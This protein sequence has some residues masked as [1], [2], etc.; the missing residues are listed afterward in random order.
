MSSDYKLSKSG[1]RYK[2][3]RKLVETSNPYAEILEAMGYEIENKKRLKQIAATAKNAQTKSSEAKPLQFTEDIEQV[4][5]LKK[6]TLRSYLSKAIPSH[7]D[8]EFISRAAR[9]PEE[10]ADAKRTADKR[11]VGII[12]AN[13]GLKSAHVAT[14]KKEDVNLDEARGRPKKMSMRSH[15]DGEGDNEEHEEHEND[16]GMEADQHIHV[17]LKKAADSDQKPFHVTFKNGKKHP[18]AQNV[19]KDILSATERLKPEHRKN[20]HDEIHQSYD[21]LASVHRLIAGK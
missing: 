2:A 18:V 19:A 8:Q 20:V 9:D 11:A 6:S 4:D 21:N 5:E 10:K 1:K 15:E 7:G 12:R 16:N 17:Q 14:M 3:H 13:K